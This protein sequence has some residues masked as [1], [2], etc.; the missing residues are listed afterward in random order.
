MTPPGS[1]A[2]PIPEAVKEALAEVENNVRLEVNL[3]TSPGEI[4]GGEKPISECL[5]GGFSV[6]AEAT[7]LKNIKKMAAVLPPH[8]A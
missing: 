8:V 3:A 5:L 7:Y 6:K 2:P 4:V 1:P